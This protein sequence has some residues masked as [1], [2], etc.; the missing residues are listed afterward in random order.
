MWDVEGIQLPDGAEIVTQRDGKV[1]IWV[2]TPPDMDGFIGRHCEECQQTFRVHGEDYEALQDLLRCVYCG[3]QGDARSFATPQQHD[4]AKTAIW[5]LAA[6]AL[7]KSVKGLSDDRQIMFGDHPYRP[8]PLARINE[9]PVVRKRSCPSCAR[10]YAVFHQHRF[11]PACGPLT[12]DVVAL[13]ALDA[14][15]ATL[16]M[17]KQMPAEQAASLRELGV[18]DQLRVN[19]LKDLVGIVE[20]LADAVFRAVVTDADNKLQ[21]RSMRNVF[22]RLDDIA[23]LFAAEGHVDLRV[24]LG[25][26]KWQRLQATWQARHL[27]VHNDGIVDTDYVAKV[28]GASNAL[29][30]Q[31]L[32]ISEQRCREAISDTRDLC[33]ALSKLRRP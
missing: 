19:A 3:R 13:D 15:T 24:D 6:Q 18:F 5:D 8:Q 31:R 2:D 22:Q 1:R 14:A 4:R 25:G 27:F 30:G 12:P 21:G 9:A 29:L 33:Q 11:C 20:T 32:V 10:R 28:G 26:A 16:D 23:N 17:L 7:L